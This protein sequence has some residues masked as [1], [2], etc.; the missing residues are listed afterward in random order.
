[1][2]LFRFYCRSITEPVV[3][4]AGRE[5]HHLLT[6]CRLGRGDSVELFDGAGQLATA[7]ITDA[8]SRKV[9]LQIKQ[10]ESH[11]R[12]EPQVVIAVSIAKG[13]RFDWL[14]AKCTEM[15]VDRICPVVFERTIKQPKNP[16]TLDRWRRL[17][18]EAAKQ[19]RRLFLPQ[20]DKPLPL[21]DV[22]GA[23]IK[24]HPNAQI[25]LGSFLES[26]P[27]LICQPFS[28]NDVIAF[29]GPEGGLTDGEQSFLKDQGVCS[30]RITDTVLRVE[31]AALVFGA[32]LTARRDTNSR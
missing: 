10:I 13:D 29:V 1:M 26:S 3:E 16:K 28:G 11:A 15:G 2:G 14:I 12:P 24:D 27:A 5:A 9:T 21:R 19:S 18:I 32:I 6:V 20:I 31:T 22:F 30:V 17:T 4:L 25:L 8:E 7:V 23:L